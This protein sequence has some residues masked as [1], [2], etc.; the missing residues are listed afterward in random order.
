V[1]DILRSNKKRQ[2]RRDDVGIAVHPAWKLDE[3]IVPNNVRSLDAVISEA[4]ARGK[5]N[6]AKSNASTRM[7]GIDHGPLRSGTA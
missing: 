4:P 3:S 1:W 7:T 5:A 2:V 6:A